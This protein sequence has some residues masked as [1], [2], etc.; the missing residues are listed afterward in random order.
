[1]AEDTLPGLP[2]AGQGS[3]ALVGEARA[4]ALAQG[5]RFLTSLR[6]RPRGRTPEA[7]AEQRAFLSSK[8]LDG[9]LIAQAEMDATPPASISSHSGSSHSSAPSGEEADASAE[10]ID[11]EAFAHARAAFD[12]PLAPPPSVPEKTYPRNVLALYRK[13]PNETIP[14]ASHAAPSFPSARSPLMTFFLKL[15]G[16]ALYTAVVGVLTGILW[17]A[18]A[19]P[20]MFATRDARAVVLA[21]ARG[22]VLRMTTHS[23]ALRRNVA[24]L[25]GQPV[26]ADIALESDWPLE[27]N[28]GEDAAR[29]AGKSLKPALKS[30]HKRV[31]FAEDTKPAFGPGDNTE[32]KE[33]SHASG[34]E[35]G[36]AQGDGEGDSPAVP[37]EPE[38]APADL[39]L[40]LR[41]ALA[42]LSATIKRERGPEE[43]ITQQTSTAPVP[44]EEDPSDY[45]FSSSDEDSDE[46][47]KDEEEELEFDPYKPTKAEKAARRAQK[48][49]RRGSPSTP[50]APAGSSDVPSDWQRGQA[51]ADLALALNNLG[52]ACETQR[53]RSSTYAAP[54]PGEKNESSS[55]VPL[56]KAEIR[57]FKGLLLRR[58]NFPAFRTG[59]HTQ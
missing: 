8:G 36:A 24:A 41:D 46:E 21:H 52:R 4:K 13:N 37:S 49:A 43:V 31:S 20:R 18:V 30:K 44:D 14:R 51:A 19:L 26:G 35:A 32:N 33:P 27:R 7:I 22:L 59:V 38:L 42:T 11:A 47:S 3:D 39:T 54:A 40:P 45:L 16:T 48:A 25:V 55:T 34:S 57:S 23:N 29:H 12:D 56:V 53:F 58:R 50:S 5:I 17:R 10:G 9:A 28:A 1:M 6:T 2:G 15:S